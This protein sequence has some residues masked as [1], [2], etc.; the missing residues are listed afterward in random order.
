MRTLAWLIGLFAVAVGLV[1]AARYN[2]GYVLLVLPPYRIEL[3]LNLSLFLLLAGFACAY[4]LVRAVS[5]AL[6]VP[7]RVREY[8]IARRRRK[9]QA[10]LVDALREFFSGRYSRAEKAG[11]RSIELREHAGLGAIVA[12]RAA[13][14]LRAYD[15]RDDYLGRA[16]ALASGDDSVRIMT[17]AELL[18]DERRFQDALDILKSLPKK[19]VA[20]LRLELRAEQQAK[21]WER[22]LVL[23]EQLAKSKVLDQEQAAQMR[24]VALSENLKSHELDAS[25]L[26]Q[27][28]QKVPASD[29]GDHKIAAAAAR[30]FMSIGDPAQACR[31]IENSVEEEWASDLLDLYSECAG[32]ETVRQIERAEEWLKSHPTDAKL[33][34][35]LGTLC[36]REGLWGKAQSYFEASISIEPTYTAHLALATLH[37]RLGDTESAQG[38]YRKSLEFAVARLKRVDDERRRQPL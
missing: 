21:N 14:E 6:Q 36:A 37:E 38:H 34:M 3:S 27:T 13:H 25:G 18:L 4:L 8:R 29:K 1:I 35:A 32:A 16:A 31:I 10:T 7:V 24:R 15:R 33:L 9:A 2:A 11:A 5:V 12:A 26:Q 30:C 20:A 19:D 23:I 28:W 22:V 17:E